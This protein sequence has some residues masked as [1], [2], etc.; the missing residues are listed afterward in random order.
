MIACT[1]SEI[2]SRAI[3][4]QKMLGPEVSIH[5]GTS[6]IGGGSLPGEVLP[7][8][9]LVIDGNTIRGGAAYLSHALRTGDTP[10]IGRIDN[11]KIL[12]DPRTILPEDES[13]FKDMVKLTL[14][15]AK[16]Q[17]I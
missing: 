4:L 12:L 2:R 15:N 6:I 10:V 8:W 7:T 16:T 1:E 11:N 17:K 5:K 13:V 14:T 9:L 3:K